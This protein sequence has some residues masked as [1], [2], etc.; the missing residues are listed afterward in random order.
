MYRLLSANFMRLRKEK[1]FWL[2]F[3]FMIALGLFFP[4]V[5]KMDE[6]KTG[7]IRDI[8]GAFGQCAIFIGILMAVFC[9][10]FIG[11]EYSDGTIRNKIISGKKRTDIYLANFTVCATAG[12][13]LCSV[14]FLSY[15]SLGIPLLGFFSIDIKA[16]VQFLLTVLFLS[17]AFSSI[18]N[19]I[20]M[21]SANK[22][23]TAATCVL[24]AFLFL[25]LGKQL[26]QMLTQPETVTGIAITDRGSEYK[27]LPNPKFRDEEE[28]RI[29]QFAYDVIPGGQVAH[30]V[31]L[32]ASN[33]SALPVYSILIIL[34]TTGAGLF[35]FRKKDLK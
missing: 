35:C 16:A 21:L 34:S 12:V 20:A 17:A 1:V 7:T 28:R 10:F 30:C 14:F 33:L 8:N 2:A 15:L 23:V 25:F 4:A 24:L 32:D 5:I 22:A 26:N 9:S 18:Y 29:V 11:K 31:S 13:I 19:L 6:I 27:E 3:F